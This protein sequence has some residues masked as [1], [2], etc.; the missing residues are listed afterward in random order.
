MSACNTW[1]WDKDNNIFS[2]LSLFWKSKSKLTRLPCCLC[3]C[4]CVWM[5]MDVYPPYKLVECLKQCL[6]NLYLINS[7]IPCIVARQRLGKHVPAATVTR[8]NRRIV[9]HVSYAVLVVSEENLW[10]CLC[11]PLVVARYWSV[12]TFPRQRRVVGGVVFYAVLVSKESGNT[13]H[14]LY[15]SVIFKNLGMKLACM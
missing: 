8:N 11:I 2:L 13:S 3:V 1:E 12:N 9:G 14:N 4:V 5:C 15:C 10:V 6:R 7:I